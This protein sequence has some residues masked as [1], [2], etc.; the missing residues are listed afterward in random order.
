MNKCVPYCRR[1]TA[2]T[3]WAQTLPSPELSQQSW[4]DPTRIP[5]L[6]P[7]GGLILKQ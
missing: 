4:T 2:E 5:D 7:T 1:H 6:T 3:L